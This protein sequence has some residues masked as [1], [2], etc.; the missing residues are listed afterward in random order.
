MSKNKNVRIL[1]Q[2]SSNV[3]KKK[4]HQRMKITKKIFLNDVKPF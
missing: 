2:N 4:L 3:R 1:T